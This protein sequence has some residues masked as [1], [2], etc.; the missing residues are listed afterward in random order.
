MSRVS[1][2]IGNNSERD[3]NKDEQY[4]PKWLFDRMGIVFDLDVAAPIGGAPH[5][6]ARR[7]YTQADDG[8]AQSWEG[9]VFMNPPYSKAKPWVEKFVSHNNGIALLP[10]SKSQWFWNLWEVADV[11]CV[12]PQNVKFQVPSGEVKNIFMQVMLIGFG[13]QAAE[14]LKTAQISRIR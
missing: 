4:T 14:V 3:P 8:L 6:P 10:T 2:K 11:I 12:I 1:I 13:D 9:L 7:Y 5:V